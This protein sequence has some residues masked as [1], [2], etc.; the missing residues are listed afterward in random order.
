MQKSFSVSHLCVF[1]F[2]LVP[3]CVCVCVAHQCQCQQKDLLSSEQ[4]AW[5][6]SNDL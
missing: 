6:D 4:M 3:R 2:V 1:V 5:K